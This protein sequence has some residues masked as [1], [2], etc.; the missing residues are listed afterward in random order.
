MC[1]SV[2]RKGQDGE[3]WITSEMKNAYINLHHLGIA[4]SVE[5]Y[6]DGKL[7]GGL[8][9]LSLGGCFFGESMFHKKN[10]RIKSC[11]ISSG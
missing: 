1:S 6:A 9:G 8:Y 2:S 11:T 3:T 5:A 10:R 7:A 4:H